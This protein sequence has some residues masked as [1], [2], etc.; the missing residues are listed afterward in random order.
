M[1]AVGTAMVIT[2]A[3]VTMIEIGVTRVTNS[4][5]WGQ[6]DHHHSRDGNHRQDT[7]LSIHA[8][9][10]S[11]RVASVYLYTIMGVRGLGATESWNTS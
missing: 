11:F 8:I 9:G 3:E 10:I 6:Y 1:T 5:R 4:I 7:D 2:A